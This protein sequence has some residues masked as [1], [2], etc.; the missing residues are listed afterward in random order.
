MQETWL[1]PNRRAILFGCVPP[2]VLAAIGVCL[3]FAL[4]E[5]A[6]NSWRYGGMLLIAAFRRSYCVRISASDQAIIRRRASANSA[7]MR[8][9]ER[10]SVPIS[11]ARP[12]AEASE[13]A[14]RADSGH[15]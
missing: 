9:K 14:L 4:G 2:L 10:D 5:S 6:G 3:L 11:S 7:I 13:S 15:V 12:A 1:K 8:L